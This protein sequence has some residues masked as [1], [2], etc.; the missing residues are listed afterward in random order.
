MCPSW[1]PV[2]RY[3]RA[4]SCRQ[5]GG[6]LLGRVARPSWWSLLRQPERRRSASGAA[7]VAAAHEPQMIAE[8]RL[9]A[10]RPLALPRR[11][12]LRR[13]LHRG[14][15][16]VVERDVLPAAAGAPEAASAQHAGD[17]GERGDVLLVVPLVEL[18]L[19]LGRD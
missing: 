2:A 4:C 15:G 13:L 8:M 18:G 3:G 7:D 11:L 12:P 9:Q 16:E 17:G 1:P 10:A 14:R 19:E 6:R 5:P